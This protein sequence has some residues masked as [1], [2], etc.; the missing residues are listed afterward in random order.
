MR[1]LSKKKISWGQQGIQ[2]LNPKPYSIDFK[3]YGWQMHLTDL[4]LPQV[5]QTLPDIQSRIV[6]QA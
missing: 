4:Q 2:T 3:H 1:E 6:M 5:E